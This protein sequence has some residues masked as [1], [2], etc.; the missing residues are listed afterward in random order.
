MIAA[1]SPF[2]SPPFRILCCC[3]G[4]GRVG[5][6][7]EMVEIVLCMR[8]R[9]ERCRVGGKRKVEVSCIG[10][11][12]FCWLR[13]TRI[14]ADFFSNRR[15]LKVLNIRVWVYICV[16]IN[17]VLW[18][19]FIGEKGIKLLRC[20]MNK[21]Q[22]LLLR[23]INGGRQSNPSISYPFYFLRLLGTL[24]K[25]CVFLSRKLNIAI[26]WDWNVITHAYLFF[27]ASL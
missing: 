14:E 15:F 9:G 27:M 19:I 18:R 4:G 7:K 25:L 11:N 8:R 24:R 12:W 6:F 13:W 16:N 1:P 10:C 20:L 5:R 17:M 21:M 2:S 23:W 26:Y 3:R 22:I